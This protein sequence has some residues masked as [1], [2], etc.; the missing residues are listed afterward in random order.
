MKAVILTQYGPP[1]VLQLQDVPTPTPKDNEVLIRNH[2]V[3]AGPSDAAFRKG[4]PFLVR[5]MYGLRKPRIKILGAEVA[6]VVEAVGRDVTLFKKGDPVFG[7]TSTNLG[8]CA[9]YLCVPENSTIVAKPAAMPYADAVGVTDGGATALTFLRDVA[10]LQPGQ[11]ILING[12]SGAV[13]AYAVQLARHHFGADVTAVC[14][15]RNIDLVKS[16]GAH[17]VIDYTRDDF[18]QNG[19]TYDV[20]FDAVGKS[21]FSRSKRALAP[22]GIYMTTVPSLGIIF[23]I[24]RTAFFGGK[25]AKFTT[26]GLK[27]TKDNLNFL[28]SQ[29]ETGKL[30]AVIDRCYPPEQIVEAH[31]Y[32]DS[33]RKKG[34]VIITFA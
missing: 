6:G 30:R 23:D 25:K 7:L 28:R 5:M 12:A 16:L 20:I 19:Q 31:R 26:A 9:E 8:G 3:S 21:S 15:A 32:V 1:E 2:A 17:R 22:R 10:H 18:T 4:E 11:K 33:E 27:Q 13:G 24:L 34:N 29:Y 14:S